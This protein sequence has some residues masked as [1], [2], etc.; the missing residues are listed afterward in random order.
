MLLLIFISGQTFAGEIE[1]YFSPE[2]KCENAVRA[3]I[4]KA[5]KSIDVMMYFFTSKVIRD[6]LLAADK[7]N[8]IIRIVLDASQKNIRFSEWRMLKEAGISV[9]F[10]EGKGLLHHK[11]A[12]IDK[13][14]VLTGSFNWTP[15]AEHNNKENM[16]IIENEELASTFT[17]HFE[18]LFKE[19]SSYTIDTNQSKMRSAPPATEKFDNFFIAS[20]RSDVFHKSSCPYAGNIKKENMTVY[21]SKEEAIKAGK[22]PCKNCNNASQ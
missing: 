8:V 4:D 20:R 7:K 12:I 18:K 16:I 19:T 14:I 1:V 10:Y 2:G 6:S 5:K 15:S 3:E 17:R 22:R 11:V 21:P 13:K 9:H